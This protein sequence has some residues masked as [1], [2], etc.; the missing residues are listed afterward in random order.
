MSYAVS[1]ALQAAV[2]QRLA[3]DAALTALVGGAVFDSPPA[4]ALPGLHVQI[5]T[6]DG[7]DVSGQGAGLLRLDLEV[8][9]R[10]EDTGFA[11][12]KA[13]AGAVSAA[14]EEAPLGLAAGR[15]VSLR[16]MR[17]RARAGVG[18]AKR[19]EVLLTFRA[20]VEAGD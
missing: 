5:G 11:A 9:V 13:A 7:R 6:E 18:R 14:L 20:L 3:G 16:L 12:V 4:G 1:G 19:R 10:G 2:Y 17:A 8:A 15:L